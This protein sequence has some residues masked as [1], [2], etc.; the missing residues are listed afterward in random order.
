MK[1]N[2]QKMRLLCLEIDAGLKTLAKALVF[3]E[4]D[5][6]S[7]QNTYDWIIQRLIKANWEVHDISNEESLKEFRRNLEQQNE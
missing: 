4:D 2:F 5:K 1:D 3:D 6:D 7:F